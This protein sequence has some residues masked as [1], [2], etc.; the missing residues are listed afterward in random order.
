VW[1]RVLD[2]CV[3]P[4][5]EPLSA[6]HA[7][8]SETRQYRCVL[9]C[10]PFAQLLHHTIMVDQIGLNIDPVAQMARGDLGFEVS[11]QTSR[12]PHDQLRFASDAYSGHKA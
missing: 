2:R 12:Q 9:A 7:R 1:R 8:T 3:D 5:Y 6:L 11:R 4:I 10:G